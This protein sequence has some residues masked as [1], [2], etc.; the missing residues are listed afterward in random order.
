MANT[1]YLYYSGWEP[2]YGKYSVMTT[3]HAEIIQHAIARGLSSVHLSTGKDVSKTRWG[4]HEVSYVSGVQLA[5]R[6]SSQAKYV[7]YQASLR[8]GLA[9][10]ARAIAPALFIRRSTTGENVHPVLHNFQ[11]Y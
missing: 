1:L 6:P 10:T 4:A 11:V 5:S 9:R 2:A 7:A 8:L 3:L